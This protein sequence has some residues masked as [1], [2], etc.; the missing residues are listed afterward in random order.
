[1]HCF[2]IAFYLSVS[3]VFLHADCSCNTVIESE[4]LHWQVAFHSLP[5]DFQYDIQGMGYYGHSPSPRLASDLWAYLIYVRG[6]NSLKNTSTVFI[7]IDV[8]SHHRV[9]LRVDSPIDSPIFTW[10]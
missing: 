1:M 5:E 7:Y 8:N 10:G 4:Q 9:R 3:S 2:L 6:I